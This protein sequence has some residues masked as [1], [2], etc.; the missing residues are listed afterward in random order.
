MM[1][2]QAGSNLND[3]SFDIKS[4]N[5]LNSSVMMSTNDLNKILADHDNLIPV[6]ESNKDNMSSE[7]ILA[8]LK[9]YE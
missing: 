3:F 1:F 6:F 5:G 9:Q 2:I 8:Y 7:K 4:D